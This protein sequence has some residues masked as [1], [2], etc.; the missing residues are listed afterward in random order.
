VTT[1]K[2]LET[3]SGLVERINDTGTGLRMNGEWCNASQYVTP[4]IDMPKVGQRVTLQVERTDCGIWIQSV[5]VL[6]GGQIHQLPIQ[7]RR[8][9]GRS[10]V[11]LREIRRLACLKAAAAFC[12]SRPD[13]KSAEVVQVAERW[14]QWV[15]QA[16]SDS[17]TSASDGA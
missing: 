2:N 3:V 10:P 17:N 15:E 12:A 9:G 14:L 4:P 7:P 11:E 1:S 5:E 13:V 8:S 6:D 16:P